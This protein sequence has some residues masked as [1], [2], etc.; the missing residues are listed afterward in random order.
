MPYRS[1]FSLLAGRPFSP[2]SALIAVLVT[3]TGSTAGV[4]ERF[5]PE[6]VEVH[7]CMP[8]NPELGD[9]R[10][11]GGKF[12]VAT[13]TDHAQP[14]P[15]VAGAWQWF[16]DLGWVSSDQASRMSG[17][18]LAN[19]VDIVFVGDGYTAPEL[20][21]F[22][23]QVTAFADEMFAEEP[24][25]T[26]RPL[27]SVHRVDVVSQDSGVSND[28]VQGISKDTA[29]DMTF[30]CNGI[31]RLLCVN[32]GLAYAYANT[33]ML[34]G[35]EQPDQVLAL[36]NTSKYGGAGYPS[37]NLG[38]ASAGNSAA[39]EI[40]VHELGHSMANLADE[41][42]YG[43]PAMFTGPEPVDANA[44][45]LTSTQMAT[46]NTKWASWL[47]TNSSVWDGSHSTFEGAVYS[48][49][50]VYRPTNNSKMRS[51][52]RPFNL[53]S[54]EAFI[55][56]IYRE[57]SPIDSFG[58]TQ[59][60]TQHT[61]V[62]IVP[63]RPVNRP[64]SIQWSF[65]GV[66][67]PGATN[68]RLDTR[69]AGLTGYG[70]LTVRAQD[71]TPWMRDEAFREAR[72]TKSYSFLLDLPPLCTGDIADDFGSPGVDGQVSFGDFLALLGLIGSCPGGS[73]GCVGDIADDF[74]TLGANGI[75]DGQVSFGDFLA[76]LGLI[77]P[78]P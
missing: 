37:N 14:T 30:W 52:Y 12:T 33:V 23:Q 10:L 17:E 16:D 78:C 44:S 32:V 76:L 77:G 20:P 3:I 58:P 62:F 21:L 24:L 55:K 67:I 4:A 48:T 9:F 61:E 72:M 60:V 64:L 71:T 26:Y 35:G 56:E 2:N 75:G 6:L 73:P 51:L 47:G 11:E 34:P 25:R 22:E 74:G 59:Y 19:R 39:V 42:D 65:K 7:H 28:P 70:L 50:G 29:L 31:E 45:K 13:S 36:A 15:G 49:N 40:V 1:S 18:N 68:E 57:V 69:A 63:V 41:Y 46:Q 5:D 27:F 38:T 43:G 53:V 66:P 8:I 54:A